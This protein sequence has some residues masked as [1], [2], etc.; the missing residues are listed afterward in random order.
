M[1]KRDLLTLHGAGT[2][3]E[4]IRRIGEKKLRRCKKNERS[5]NTGW[6]RYAEILPVPVD[7]NEKGDAAFEAKGNDILKK[8]E[9]FFEV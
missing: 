5:T 1:R 7:S 2:Y 8:V 4:I 6:C 9:H 3:A